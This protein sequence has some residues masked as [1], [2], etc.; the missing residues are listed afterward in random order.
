MRL[1]TVVTSRGPRLH[2]R[3]VAGYVDVADATGQAD[4]AT[5][6]GLLASGPERW[7][8]VR[9]AAEEPGR[10]VE[11]S[12]LGPAVPAPRRILCLGVNYAENAA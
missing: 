3:G 2:V 12:D 10:P 5:L 1:A 7:E 4:L 9:R 6:Q 11:E 8:L